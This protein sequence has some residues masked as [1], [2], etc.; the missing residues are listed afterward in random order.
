MCT[1]QSGV[2]YSLH[3]S[4]LAC[5]LNMNFLV[6]SRWPRWFWCVR[7]STP[8]LIALLPALILP[9]ASALLRSITKLFSFFTT[10]VASAALSANPH[11]CISIINW[12][13]NKASIKEIS[14]IKLIRNQSVRH[15]W[16]P[17]DSDY[18]AIG[19]W[20]RKFWRTVWEKFRIE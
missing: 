8:F 16:L 5:G 2:R 19:A 4:A 6:V 11:N 12:L 15:Y 7:W 3:F 18:T 13:C 14:N 1:V 10:L 20:W 9:L 17:R